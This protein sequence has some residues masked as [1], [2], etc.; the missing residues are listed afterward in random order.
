MKKKYFG[1]KIPRPKYWRGIIIKPKILNFGVKEII[2]CTIENFI[3]LRGGVG[4]QKDTFSIKLGCV[5]NFKI[6][7]TCSNALASSLIILI[8]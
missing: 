8:L 1:L 4:R 2:D 5:F 3:F 6:L 7:K